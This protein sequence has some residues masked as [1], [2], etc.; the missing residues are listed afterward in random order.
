[1]RIFSCLV[2]IGV[3]MSLVAGAVRGGESL[4]PVLIWPQEAPGEKGDIGEE[5]EQPLKP[6]D[7]TI[8]TANV[9]KPTLTIFRPTPEKNTGA[10]VIICPGG[11]YNILAFNKEGTEVAEWLSSIGVTGIVLKYRV[12][13]RKG[14]E[15]YTAPL[16]DCAT[17]RGV[18][19]PSSQ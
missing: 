7:S 8:R 5:A 1:M 19:S 6:G 3:A 2:S 17:G 4:P 18:G 16:Q 12:P 10:A 11:G 13:A 15:K 14:L 9:T